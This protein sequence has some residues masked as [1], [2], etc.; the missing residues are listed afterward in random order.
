L[1]WLIQK[2]GK[3]RL[4]QR[5]AIEREIKITAVNIS[6]E[7]TSQELKQFLFKTKF[8]SINSIMPQKSEKNKD[9]ENEPK[10]GEGDAK[11]RESSSEAYQ[12]A[13]KKVDTATAT[14]PTIAV[15][16][17]EPVM[18]LNPATSVSL[19]RRLRPLAR[20]TLRAL[21]QRA[22]LGHRCKQAPRSLPLRQRL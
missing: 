7:L 14:P 10:R 12:K 9:N 5:N 8:V 4:F 21:R 13:E 18:L 1:L 20:R 6:V 22:R 3:L 19:W 16:N 11:A 17:D 2:A 15:V